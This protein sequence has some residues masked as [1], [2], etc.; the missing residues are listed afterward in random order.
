M[1]KVS[2]SYKA[3]VCASCGL[4]AISSKELR[5]FYCRRC[6]KGAEVLSI[7]LPYAAKQLVQELIAMHVCP[8]MSLDVA[9]Y[10]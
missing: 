2:D 6:Q 8:R 1:L 3:F 7:Q 10:K 4:F 9:R 5:E